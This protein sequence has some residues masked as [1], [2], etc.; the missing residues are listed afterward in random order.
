KVARS[1]PA[2]AGE[3]GFHATSTLGSLGCTSAAAKLSGLNSEQIRC[4]L[5]IASSM[6]SGS[7]GNFGTMTKPLHAGIAARNGV[8][9]ARLAQKGF[10][11]SETA[12]DDKGAF[13]SAIAPGG[14]PDIERFE[15]LGRTWDVDGGIRYKF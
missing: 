12:L 4:A 9:A 3:G 13:Y 15:D 1:M 2:G 8:T 14:P 6:A 10:T 11:G 7:V 5:G